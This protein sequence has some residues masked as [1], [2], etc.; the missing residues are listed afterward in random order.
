[1]FGRKKEDP[2]AQWHQARDKMAGVDWITYRGLNGSEGFS[3]R[4]AGD[5][6]SYYNDLA[7]GRWGEVRKV[8]FD[9]PRDGDLPWEPCAITRAATGFSVITEDF[10]S[11]PRRLKHHSTHPTYEEAFAAVKKLRPWG[12]E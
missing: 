9:S 12:M 10:S 1:V 11:Q 5:L 8:W 2:L 4:K 3:T 7:T 6:I